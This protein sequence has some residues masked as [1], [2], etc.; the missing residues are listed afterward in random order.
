MNELKI[1][2]PEPVAEI[3]P[4]QQEKKVQFMGSLIK[5]PNMN[6]WRLDIKT[7]DV[8]LAPME[9]IYVGG[10]YKNEVK[11]EPGYYYCYALNGKNAMKKFIKMLG[12]KVS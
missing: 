1:K 11:M 8:D 7:G 9:L 6:V 3:K 4:V 10:K 5:K 2:M 12:W